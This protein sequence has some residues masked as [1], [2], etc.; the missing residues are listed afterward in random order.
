MQRFIAK[1]FVFPYKFRGLTLFD[2]YQI[3]TTAVLEDETKSQVQPILQELLTPSTLEPAYILLFYLPP[4]YCTGVLGPTIVPEQTL[5]VFYFY[6]VTI[7]F[8]L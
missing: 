5:Q 3:V 2:S 8:S 7:L 6:N 4:V 1:K